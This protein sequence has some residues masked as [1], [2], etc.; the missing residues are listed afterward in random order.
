VTEP[1]LAK[2]VVRAARA[3]RLAVSE[4]ARRTREGAG[5]EEATQQVIG[6]GLHFR[7]MLE[8]CPLDGEHRDASVGAAWT[9]LLLMPAVLRC[10]DVAYNR[11]AQTERTVQRSRSC[12]LLARQAMASSRS[13]SRRTFS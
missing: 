5:I 11:M 9:T 4:L 7:Q 1:K 2:D 10:V 3:Y 13:M 6:T 12:V 8:R